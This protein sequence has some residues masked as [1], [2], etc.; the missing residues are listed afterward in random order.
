MIEEQIAITPPVPQDL[1][2]HSTFSK[3]DSAV[4]DQQT[5]EFIAALG[6]AERVGI[7]DHFESFDDDEWD[8]YERTVRGHGL[9]LATEV[10]GMRS[11]RGA[12]DVHSQIHFDY[13]VYHCYDF[14]DSYRG[15]ELLL[16][17][18]RPVIIAHPNALD[19]N[20]TRVAPEC[21]IEINNRYVWRTD[22]I[23]YYSPHVHRFQFVIDSDA[24]QPNWLNQNVAR[25]AARKLGVRENLLF[26][27]NRKP[28]ALHN[29]SE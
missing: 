1:H 10:D 18:G 14:S 19:T 11:V 3:T 6:H 16:E 23:T 20:L 9:Y 29:L 4:V 26:E 25:W 24:H 12:L 5:I 17:T 2:I 22:F 8:E 21:H 7:S 27:K 13:F 28:M 15:A